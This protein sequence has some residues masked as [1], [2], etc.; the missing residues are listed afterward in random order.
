MKKFFMSIIAATIALSSVFA[1]CRVLGH[2]ERPG[3]SLN[4]AVVLSN[5]PVMDDGGFYDRLSDVG[6][7][8]CGSAVDIAGVRVAFLDYDPDW[9]DSAKSDDY[10]YVRAFFRF[11]NNSDSDISCGGSYF[12]CDAD[13]IDCKSVYVGDVET[14]ATSC[15]LKPEQTIDGWVYYE[16]PMN[17]Q[18]IDV[19]YKAGDN[20]SYTFTL[21]D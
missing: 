4:Q 15:S 2:S 12:L 21:D 18:V 1:I 6:A 3:G 10:R 5:M 20:E 13:G 11:T 8:L 19:V 14:L 17:A 7:Y 16:V 9:V